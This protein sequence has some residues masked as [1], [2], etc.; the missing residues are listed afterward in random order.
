M[1]QEGLFFNGK[2][3]LDHSHGMTHNIAWN[4]TVQEGPNKSSRRSWLLL[5]RLLGRMLLLLMMMIVLL[6]LLL[7]DSRMCT[8]CT[9]GF[10][11]TTTDHSVVRFVRVFGKWDQCQFTF[12]VHR[13]KGRGGGSRYHD[14]TQRS[15]FEIVF[16]SLRT[17]V[18]RGM[19]FIIRIAIDIDSLILMRQCCIPGTTLSSQSS[20]LTT[21]PIRT[22][23]TTKM[24]CSSTIVAIIIVAVVVS[25]VV[26][27]A[28]WSIMIVV[29]ADGI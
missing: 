22:L 26:M 6:L 12:T 5:R 9:R 11:M 21:M 17:T 19:T 20:S 3:T 14:G 23:M 7:F 10:R 18:F 4:R 2:V 27:S 25:M 24:S 16:G 8:T 28:G 13:W 1:K 15:Q 29:V